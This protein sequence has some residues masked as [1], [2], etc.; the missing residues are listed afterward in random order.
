MISS[1]TPTAQDSAV[2]ELVTCSLCEATF[3]TESAFIQHAQQ[4]HH[5]VDVYEM[6]NQ[7]GKIIKSNAKDQ[8]I[9]FFDFDSIGNVGESGNETETADNIQIEEQDMLSVD[10]EPSMPALPTRS[11]RSRA[12]AKSKVKT[13]T[14]VQSTKRT[15]PAT[16]EKKNSAKLS[17]K[18]E[19]SDLDENDVDI[20]DDY[21]F[22]QSGSESLDFYECPLCSTQFADRDEYIQHCREH[23]GTEYQCEGCN[24][25]FEDEHQLLQ[26]EC[27]T[28]D[29]N[30]EDLLCVPYVLY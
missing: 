28:T 7:S 26:H 9:E 17:F 3:D 14:L 25:L 4:E 1:E 22:E 11:M 16:V 10:D 27:D 12:A 19:I 8:Q 6:E 2:Q 13:E 30:D 29:M 18:T 21:D 5:D 24:K 20:T 23:D 15:Q